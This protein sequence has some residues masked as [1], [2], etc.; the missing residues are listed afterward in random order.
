MAQ[1]WW[2]R[3]DARLHD[4]PALIAAI[5]AGGPVLPL[6]IVDPAF[7]RSPFFSER[8]WAFL[9]DVLRSLDADLRARGSRLIVRRGDPSSVIGALR[10]EG[11]AETV[12]TQ[13]DVSP[14]GRARERAVAEVAPLRALQG[15]TVR[16]PD[17]VHKQDGDPYTV[18]TPYGRAWRNLPLPTAGDLLPAPERIP[19]PGDLDDGEL[20]ANPE[21]RHADRFPASE[22]GARAR[23]TA[24]ADGPIQ[25][26]A[27]GRN[28]LDTSMTS[29]LSPYFRFG[30]L[31]AREA[32][33]AALQ[34]RRR[35]R[36]DEARRGADTWLNELIWREFY[37]Q[38]LYHFP[39]VRG[40]SFRP[41]YDRVQW[42][43]DP[44]GLA[45]WQEGRT[46]YPVVDAAMRQLRETG[47]IHNRARMIVASFLVKDLLI[48]WRAGERWFMA[49]LL[50]GDPGSNNGGW[51]W[52]AGTGTDAAPYFRIFNP[53]TQSKKFDPEGAFIRR[54]VP[55]LRA[56]PVDYLHEPW[57][58]PDAVQAE[59]GCR[60]GRDYPGPIVD[61]G[62]AR[63]RT[64][65]AYAA[66]REDS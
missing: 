36:S 7:P 55:E 31:S 37:A 3:R 63:Q 41:E 6:F 61:H 64:L 59:A 18:F 57:K 35:A 29:S 43:D 60:I 32:A 5:E 20:P 39:R 22:A 8:R 14:L 34:A 38:I 45:A 56:V 58:M 10:A 62:A 42:R 13:A 44:D 49:H 47:W 21:Y 40:A 48:D 26:Y 51:Q 24:F 9:L 27:A 30:L 33:V 53:I 12:F 19:S 2:I 16:P 1:V 25:D 65:D 11:L 66:A 15:L 23:L 54:H 17:V 52:T 46:G 50:D 4:N 28:Q